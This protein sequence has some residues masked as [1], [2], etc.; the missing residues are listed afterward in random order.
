MPNQNIDTPHFVSSHDFHGDAE[1]IAWL[2]ELKAR[3]Q[4]IRSRIALQANYG[5]LE[6]NWKRPNNGGVLVSWSS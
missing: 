3:Y 4:H 2:S 6:F 1:Y 5:L